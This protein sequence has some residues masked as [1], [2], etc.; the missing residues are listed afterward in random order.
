MTTLT[1]NADHYNSMVEELEKHFAKLWQEVNTLDEL[2]IF[3]NR[4]RSCGLEYL[5]DSYNKQFFIDNAYWLESEKEKAESI[6]QF[7]N[8]TNPFKDGNN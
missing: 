1:L 6:E 8:H 3:M 7:N 2:E 5:A 4:I